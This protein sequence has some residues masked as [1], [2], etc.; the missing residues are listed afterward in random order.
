MLHVELSQVVFLGESY[1]RDYTKI[2]AKCVQM[3]SGNNQ[4]C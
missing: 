1:R 4:K 2:P 3:N